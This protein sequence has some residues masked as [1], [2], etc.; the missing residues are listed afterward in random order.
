V[1]VELSSPTATV[2]PSRPPDS[3]GWY[4]R[5]V[6]GTPSA[7]SFSGIASC[8]STTYAGPDSTAATVSATC[9]DHAGKTVTATSAPFAYD[10]TPPSLAAAASPADR[11]VTLSWQAGGDLAPVVSVSVK[12][13]SRNGHGVADTIYRG[14]ADHYLDTHVRNG[15]P[16]TYTI[17]A[18][19]QA[20]HATVRTVVAV[21]GPRLLAPASAAHLSEPPMLRWTPVRGATY[22][23]VQLF[24]G[25]KVLSIWP[26]RARLQLH[27]RWRFNGH[28]YRLAPGR[29]RWFVWPGFGKRSARRYGRAIGSGTF[30]VIR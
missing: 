12:R 16:Y 26:D 4:N 18:V 23:N 29:Y 15:V 22:Y 27:R 5:P 14:D 21:P 2:A 25:G 7:S 30:V 13:S 9:V 1:R 19:D 3:S 24:R 28:R 10:V 17:T 8:T 11:K 6:L 20:G